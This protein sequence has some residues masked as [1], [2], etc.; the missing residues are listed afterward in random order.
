MALDKARDKAQEKERMHGKDATLFLFKTRLG[1]S[2][3]T[4]A[5][6]MVGNMAANNLHCYFFCD[7]TVAEE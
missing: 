1:L 2:A 5:G 3:F 7:L 6:N 4:L